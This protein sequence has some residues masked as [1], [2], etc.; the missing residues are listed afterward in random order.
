[1]GIFWNSLNLWIGYISIK[2]KS[3]ADSVVS[4]WYLNVHW[5]KSKAIL[6]MVFINRTI[7]A[8]GLYEQINWILFMPIK[9]LDSSQTFYKSWSKRKAMVVCKLSVALSYLEQVN[10]WKMKITTTTVSVLVYRLRKLPLDQDYDS[11]YIG[12]FTKNKA[13]EIGFESEGSC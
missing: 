5:I 6:N 7:S 2:P 11:N 10:C 13:R 1:M 4:L 9:G 12:F 3:K 8:P